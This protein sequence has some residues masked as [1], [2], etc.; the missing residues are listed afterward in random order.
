MAN[1]LPLSKT[2]EKRELADKLIK[3]KDKW[4]DDPVIN[5]AT[6]GS[7]THFV[8]FYNETLPHLDFEYSRLPNKKEL[9]KLDRNISRYIKDIYK[10]PTKLGELFKLPEVI[11]RKNPAT[12]T[13][14][15]SLVVASQ[16]YRG[17]QS[18]IGSDL[19][20]I[21]T[22]LNKASGQA[23]FMQNYGYNRSKASIEIAKLETAYKKL[24][25]DGKVEL[26]AKFYNDRLKNL[27]EDGSL[28]AANALYYLMIDPS[29]V[30]K[31][32][33]KKTKLEFGDELA[34]AARIWHY[35]DP[36][37]GSKSLKGRLWRLLGNGL[38]TNIDL[39]KQM[40]NDYNKGTFK[41]QKLEQIYDEYFDPKKASKRV[42]DYF[43]RQVLDIAP[44]FSKLSEDIHSGKMDKSSIDQKEIGTYIERMI[45][46]L[47]N[48]LKQ[49]G[50]VYERTDP[51]PAM[52]SKD[53]LGILDSYAQNVMRF[54]YSAFV[55]KAT[56]KALK[57]L[58]KQEG[59][60]LDTQIGF[61]KDYVNDTHQSVLGL[62]YRNSKFKN[63]ARAITSWQFMSKLGFNIRSAARNATQA[64]QDWVWFG[65]KA[66]YEAMKDLQVDS[67]RR[68]VDDAMRKNGFEFVNIQEFAVPKGL[69]G[70]V[71]VDATGKVVEKG[72]S[73]GAKFNDWLENIA[74]ITGKP[75]QWVENHV[76]RGLTFKI[77]FLQK[78]NEKNDSII[79]Q[80]VKD[81]YKKPRDLSAEEYKVKLEEKIENHKQKIASR[82]ATDV[83]KELHY[84]YDAW[85]KPKVLRNPVGSV[86][87]QF[88]T[89]SINFFEYQRKILSKGGNDLMHAEWN[90]PEAWRMYR[91]GMLYT[92]V[93]ALS[94]ATNTQWSNLIENDTYERIVR[95]NQWLGGTA[96]EKEKAFFGQGPV[97]ATFGGPF[98]SDML[99]IGRLI[100]FDSMSGDE[101]KSYAEEYKRFNKKTGEMEPTEE[102]VRTLNTQIG[103]LIY[104][105]GPR[106]IGG[107]SFPTVLG[108]E[109]GLYKAR[110]LEAWR[111]AML[112]PLQKWTPKPVSE[113]FTPPTSKKVG[114]SRFSMDEVKTILE[115]LGNI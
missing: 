113:Y 87:G 8:K 101:L 76:N 23:G 57:G 15:K 59:S 1:C 77:A 79:R 46:D 21:K 66:I 70:N 110:D 54:N 73:T 99:R 7:K 91:L 92:F 106:I 64:L 2:P 3:I 48:N 69:L 88:T 80:S 107:T 4:F 17:N 12:K 61:L 42:K 104:N 100:N 112:Y 94:A 40:E 5:A 97:T 108:Q 71:E 30:N 105:T 96:E 89:Y 115:S 56:T 102:I 62:K 81:S 85:A 86:L 111:D 20:D 22:L 39:L 18:S 33:Y 27:S 98:V 78:Y 114:K 72:A 103:R 34:K 16:E 74:R 68:I 13:Y 28:S 31:Q 10:K 52:V 11:L 75:M 95:L 65:N 35:G 29:I 36:A 84:L 67:K 38:K 58:L 51:A 90:T 49:P 14:F 82:Y 83:V 55:T 24:I 44:T 45:E 37:T 60:N 50:V 41:I 47:T 43:P 6:N 19:L 63:I 53:V 32:N 93:T 9:K 109:L 25:Q 26:A